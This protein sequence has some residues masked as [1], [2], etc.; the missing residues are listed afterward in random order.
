MSHRLLKSTG[1]IMIVE[2]SDEDYETTQRAF[3]KAGMANHMVRFGSG[4]E[5][6]DYLHRCG[7]YADPEVSP[8]PNVILLDLYLPGTDGRAVLQKIKTHH[9]LKR[10]PVI[11]LT[12]SGDMRDIQACYD[13]GASSYVHKPVDL[14]SYIT[15]IQRLSEYWFQIVVLP[16]EAQ[17]A[18]M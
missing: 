2:D 14:N 16:K 1:T 6:L 12:T 5:A 9:E 18:P 4:D 17:A 10:I 8:R 15:A 3:R 7:D 11:V 13:A